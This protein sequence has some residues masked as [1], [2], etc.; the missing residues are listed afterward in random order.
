MWR[1]TKGECVVR[2]TERKLGGRRGP[3]RPWI[4]RAAE[5]THGPWDLE[6]SSEAMGAER[7]VVSL[8]RSH[9]FLEEFEC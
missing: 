9:R 4:Y 1:L 5:A 6:L 2:R 3:S 7:P 8:Q